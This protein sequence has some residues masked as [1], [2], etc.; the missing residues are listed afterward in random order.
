MNQ[1]TALSGIKMI[2]FDADDTLWENQ[3]LFDEV[4]ASFHHILERNLGKA[5]FL[6]RLYETQMQNMTLFGYGAKSF[7]LSMIET[8]LQLT[9]FTI[10]ATDIQEIIDLGKSLLTF[11]IQLLDGVE[12]V[13][14]ALRHRY[15]LMLITKGDLFD[16]ESK[17]ARSGVGDCFTHVEIVSEK[18]ETAYRKILSRYQLAPHELLMVGNSLKSDILPVANLGCPAVYI[19]FHTSAHFDKAE[20]THE[21]FI[22][23]QTI[24]ELLQLL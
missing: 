15:P 11:P 17:I 8:A 18:D 22:T 19:P 21:N 3:P 12:K 2:A 14:E 6:K 9:D 16:Q 20:A 23:I 4:E 7:M 24:K 13:L 10:K 1:A 5:D